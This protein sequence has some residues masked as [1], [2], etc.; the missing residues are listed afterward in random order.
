MNIVFESSRQ[1]QKTIAWPVAKGGLEAFQFV[2]VSFQFLFWFSPRLFRFCHL[3]LVSF[4]VLFGFL[5][6]FLVFVN[7]FSL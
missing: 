7:T 5:H 4:Q 2:L 1:G 3:F 6:H